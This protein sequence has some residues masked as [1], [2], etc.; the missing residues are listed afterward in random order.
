MSLAQI[1]TDYHVR[2]ESNGSLE[3]CLDD[4]VKYIVESTSIKSYLSKIKNKTK[5][6]GL[7]YKDANIIVKRSFHCT[8]NR[9]TNSFV[10]R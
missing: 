2:Y 8:K 3:L 5:R 7:W 6:N 9:T 1:L 4:F 10:W